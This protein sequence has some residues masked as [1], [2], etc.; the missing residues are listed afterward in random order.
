[1]RPT[2]FLSAILIVGCD[3]SSKSLSELDSDSTTSTE[4]NTNTNTDG[5]ADADT[6]ADTDADADTDTDTFTE[7]ES[8]FFGREPAK[9]LSVPKFTAF[10]LDDTER[11]QEAL[12][13]Q[14]TVMWFFPAAGTYG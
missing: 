8:G 10:N 13:G 2:L 7:T 9:A 4:T 11:S 1:M 12:V 5:D 6:D 14:P 3:D